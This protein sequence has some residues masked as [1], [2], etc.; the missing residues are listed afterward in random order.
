MRRAVE[1]PRVRPVGF[2]GLRLD[3]GIAPRYHP[4]QIG[5]KRMESTLHRQ[6]KAH[7][8]GQSAACEVRVDGYRI[9]A[10][11]D[12]RLIE[13]QQASLSALRT[14]VARLL[15]RHFVVVVKPLCARKVIVRRERCTG[16][17]ISRRFS[18]TRETLWDVFLDLVHFVG[19]VP[20][21]RLTLEVVLV[22]VEEHRA[23]A[24]RRWRRA[25][26]RVIDRALTAIQS[27]HTFRTADDW[28]AL[29]PSNL[30]AEFTTAELATALSLPRWWAQ[31]V[32]YCLRKIGAL[33]ASRRTRRG[34][35]YSLPK[36]RAA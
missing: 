16:R 1:N 4:P 23:E 32:A 21:P 10:V 5:W 3:E 29:L 36:R 9:D 8:A 19:V 30:P 31:K 15:E 7:Y 28:L 17:V 12:G 6:L 14:K 33:D 27:Q 22:E 11:V 24:G 35:V 34:W 26:E 18:P 13:I 2:L 20:H 25:N